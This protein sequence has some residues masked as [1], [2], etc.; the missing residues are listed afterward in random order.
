ML[1]ALRALGSPETIETKRDQVWGR[2]Q[3]HVWGIS[4]GHQCD[5]EGDREKRRT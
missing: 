5:G 3:K 2:T 4:K 1:E